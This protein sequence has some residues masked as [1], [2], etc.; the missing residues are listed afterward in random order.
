M[1]TCGCCVRPECEGLACTRMG[2]P[3]P[4]NCGRVAVGSLGVHPNHPPMPCT[5]P[6][7]VQGCPKWRKMRKCVN[8]RHVGECAAHP[9]HALLCLRLI[10][11]ILVRIPA[12]KPVVRS[13]QDDHQNTSKSA[14]CRRS[15]PRNFH[16]SHPFYAFPPGSSCFSDLPEPFQRQNSDGGSL[17]VRLQHLR[18]TTS[19][20]TAQPRV[21]HVQGPPI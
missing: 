15:P 3:A 2:I 13:C 10:L 9:S 12:V 21:C 1:L 17:Q 16:L 11:P 6:A 18:D 7:T 8:F 20:R 5:S 4:S 19:H 14:M